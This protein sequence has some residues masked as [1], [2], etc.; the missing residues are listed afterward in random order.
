MKKEVDVTPKNIFKYDGC[1]SSLPWKLE[2]I[3]NIAAFGTFITPVIIDENTYPSLAMIND[4]TD[5]TF[6]EI[7]KII[8]QNRDNFLPPTKI[9]ALNHE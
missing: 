6:P 4:H 1:I 8:E 5:L 2:E 7:A 9:P 3:L